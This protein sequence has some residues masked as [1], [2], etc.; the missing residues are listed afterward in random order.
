MLTK[1]LSC[2][3]IS[4]GEPAPSIT[5]TS[6]S[7]RS[8][9]SAPRDDAA[10]RCALR[11]RQGMRVSAVVDLPEQHHLAVRVALGL[12]Q[13]RVHAHLGLGA[14]RQRLEVLRAADLAGRRQ[15][16]TTRALLLMFCALNGATFR[17]WRAYQRHSAVASQLLPA[18]L[19]VP[20]TMTQRGRSMRSARLSPAAATQ[21]PA[22][23]M[24]RDAVVEHR[25]PARG[26]WR[27]RAQAPWCTTRPSCHHHQVVGLQR[28][29]S[30]SCSTLTTVPPRA[31]WRAHDAPA[32]RPGAAGRGWPAARPSAARGAC[33]ASAR[34][35][36][37]RWRSPPDSWPSGR[38]RQSQHCVSRIAARTAAWSAALGARQ[39]GLVR[40]AAQHH[41]VVRQQVVGAAFA[42]PQP[43]QRRGR[44]RA[45]ATRP[46]A[47]P[48]SC[49]WP[50]RAAAGCASALSRWSCRRRW[51][52][53]S[54]SSG[55][56]AAPGRCRAAPR[57]PPSAHAQAARCSAM[58]RRAAHS[59]RRCIS[60]SR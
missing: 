55:R 33:T 4:A 29:A 10:T 60:H 31:T 3:L 34:A 57:A 59:G 27:R 5:T 16:A 1:S 30:S 14:R 50:L 8:A 36:S 21:R 22:E 13:H 24:H 2:R 20:S 53:R 17:P 51:G 11:S 41:D 35:S 25:A 56:P 6:F 12:E 48:S 45:P 42:L 9:S 38:S 46:A 44:A 54:R 28:H 37:T 58:R 7:A 40:Q 15:P 26:A 43:G 39:P 49:T 47:R 23:R 19:V 52:R 18:P 32:S